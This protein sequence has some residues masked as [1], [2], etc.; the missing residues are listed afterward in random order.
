[1]SSGDRHSFLAQNVADL[2][3]GERYF[4]LLFEQSGQFLLGQ[5]RVLVL[6]VPQ[7]GSPLWRPLGSV[8]MTM[9][10]QRFP[11]RSSLTIVTAQFRHIVPTVRKLQ[12]FTEHLKV[13]SLV[14]S[15]EKLLL[16]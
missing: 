8:T 14:E 7:P 4:E 16:C 9:I 13:L 3:L 2:P 15:L 11:A 12:F 6:L 1:L 5:G 10:Y